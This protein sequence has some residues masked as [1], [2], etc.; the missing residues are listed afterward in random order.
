MLRRQRIVESFLTALSQAATSIRQ[1]LTKDFGTEVMTADASIAPAGT[2]TIVRP[3][4]DETHLG[5]AIAV[6]ITLGDAVAAN[7]TFSLV[8]WDSTAELDTDAR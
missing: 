2:E 8:R 5:D 7:S 4:M 6:D 3:K 1:T